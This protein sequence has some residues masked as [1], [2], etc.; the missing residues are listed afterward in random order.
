MTKEQEALKLALEALEWCQGGEPCGTAAAITAINEALAQPEQ[1]VAHRE[2]FWCVDL[3]CRKCYG[4][5]FRFK[6]KSSVD[7][8]SLTTPAQPEERNFCPRCGKR[9][10][11]SATIHT[12]TPPQ[13]IAEEHFAKFDSDIDLAVNK[14]MVEE[15]DDAQD[16]VRPW[17]GL[18]FEERNGIWRKEIGWGDPSHNDEDL[19]KAI[20]AKLKEKNV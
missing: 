2:A 18:T 9:T 15:D 6:H 4:A 10:A 12:C 17:V 20:E 14:A 19:M 8:K 7:K 5:D 1:L 13:T 3:T 16:Y 11:D